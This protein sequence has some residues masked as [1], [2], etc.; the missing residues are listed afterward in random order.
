MAR[1]AGRK[2]I[3]WDKIRLEFITSDL[4]LIV[5]ADKHNVSM[6]SIRTH[7]AKEKW[8]DQREA[9]LSKAAD[10]SI[11]KDLE[12]RANQLAEFDTQSIEMAKELF[13]Q[14]KYHFD[15]AKK[16]KKAIATAPLASL[17]GTVEKAQKIGRLALGAETENSKLSGLI[18]TKNLPA[19][20]SLFDGDDEQD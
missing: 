4:T 2:V 5:L 19:M 7:A 8:T 9:H 16:A 1:T 10:M 13:L 18:Q 11:E 6:S 17:S 3:D 20:S 14:A 12:R 15:T